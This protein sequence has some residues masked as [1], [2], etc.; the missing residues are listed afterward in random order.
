MPRVLVVGAG[1]TGLTAALRL[2]QAG[3]DVAVL[4][5][6]AAVGGR[7]SATRRDG[8][9]I[10]RAAGIIPASYTQLRGLI[11][12]LG[13][14]SRTTLVTTQLEIP[15]GAE[16][17][18]MRTAGPG[19]LVDGL[20]SRLLSRRSKLLLGRLLLDATRARGRLGYEDPA[21]A[22]ALDTESAAAYCRRRLNDQI[23]DRV[24]DPVCRG[25]FLVGPEDVSVADLHF[26]ILRILGRPQVR[27]EGGIDLIVQAIADRV[28]VRCGAEVA[29]V[30][31]EAGRVRVAWT[32]D[33]EPH[34]ELVDGCVLAVTGQA[35]PSLH[36]GLDPE[37][38]RYLEG[39]RW[40]SSIV[41]HFALDRRPPGTALL[42]PIPASEGS[43]LSL[44]VFHEHVAPDCAPPGRS[45]V[46]GYWMHDYSQAHAHLSDGELRPHLVAEMERYVPG[47]AAATSFTLIDRWTPVVIR[48]DH[49]TYAPL[50]D[51][52]ARLDPDD[53]IQLAGDYFGYGSTNRCSLTGER[54]ARNL[55]TRLTGPPAHPVRPGE[56]PLDE[57]PSAAG[58]GPERSPRLDLRPSR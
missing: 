57:A 53:A 24:V 5:R 55:I 56:R 50:A 4:E 35:V 41:A 46:S 8:F 16:R 22:V 30:E 15:V 52:C 14:T 39:T 33:G 58:L 19:M 49:G 34:E 27:Y 13:L 3:I 51:F 18:R 25:M 42:T 12:E 32:E 44:V 2:H 11:D 40:A 1:I 23:L 47:V 37:Q 21:G 9:V 6:D 36:P 26:M 20:R 48:C 31:Y 10:N 28:P 29:R 43:P 45:L 7:M 38:R 17:H 54:A